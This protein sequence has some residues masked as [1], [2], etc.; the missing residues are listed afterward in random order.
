M[1]IDMSGTLIVGC[2]IST[3]RNIGS[4]ETLEARFRS[5]IA[6]PVSHIS[7]ILEEMKLFREF[8]LEGFSG[9]NYYSEEDIDPPVFIGVKLCECGNR[10][11][12]PIGSCDW[13]DVRLAK[14]KVE[15][16]L[17]SKGFEGTIEVAFLLGLF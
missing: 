14:R 12:L 2:N 10:G 13:S 1:G 17:R 9:F 16:A 7:T 11:E 8:G 4:D 3:C 6:N 5:A 15:L